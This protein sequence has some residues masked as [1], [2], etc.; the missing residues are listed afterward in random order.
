MKKVARVIF[1]Y[2]D[3]SKHEIRDKKAAVLF[4]ARVNT[5]GILSGLENA[6]LP[7]RKWWQFDKKIELSNERGLTP[8]EEERIVSPRP[9][10]PNTLNSLAKN[11]AKW[12]EEKGFITGWEN[13]PEKLMLVVTEL[14]EAMEAYRKDDKKNFNE[15][16]ADTIIRLCDIVGSLGIDIED[17]I[18]KKMAINKDR[19]YK[20]G[21][22]C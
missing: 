18:E 8:R 4:Q 2:D 9:S 11:I 17:E 14:S 1:I 20:H 13:M 21:K 12:R 7:P 5:S 6:I 3:G 19:D 15:E 16:I 10:R 22:K